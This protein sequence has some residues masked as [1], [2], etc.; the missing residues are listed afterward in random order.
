MISDN[1]ARNGFFLIAVLE[2]LQTA[3]AEQEEEYISNKLLKRISGLKKAR[4]ADF[5]N[6]SSEL[7]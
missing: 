4:S 7:S 1:F 6:V 3:L 2:L 5:G